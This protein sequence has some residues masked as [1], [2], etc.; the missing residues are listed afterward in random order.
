[1]SE[2]AHGRQWQRPQATLAETARA[3]AS[4]QQ[5][6]GADCDTSGTE[7][8]QRLGRL[9]QA[10]VRRQGGG[11]DLAGVLKGLAGD[12]AEMQTNPAFSPQAERQ[13][14]VRSCIFPCSKYLGKGSR[15]GRAADLPEVGI[16][17]GLA[18]SARGGG[19]G[20]VQPA[21]DFSGAGG[22]VCRICRMTQQ[23]VAAVASDREI[24]S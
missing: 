5:E 15:N 2:N 19:R 22:C 11:A 10:A 4:E 6:W 21:R 24:R 20:G 18:G 23:W 12:A 7:E 8:V 13:P 1:M 14:E 16:K 17:L 9:L 3:V